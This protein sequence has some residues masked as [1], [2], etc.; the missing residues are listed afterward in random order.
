[1]SKWL[2]FMSD[3]A[4]EID[5][6]SVLEVFMHRKEGITFV[7]ELLSTFYLSV[8][9]A[10]CADD[11]VL[12]RSN[13]LPSCFPVCRI[14]VIARSVNVYD[15]PSIPSKKLCKLT[16]MNSYDAFDRFIA[17]DGNIFYRV[18]AGWCA[19]LDKDAFPN[20]EVIN[21]RPQTHAEKE[22]WSHR[23]SDLTYKQK[24]KQLGFCSHYSLRRFGSSLLQMLLASISSFNMKLIQV[25]R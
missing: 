16:P 10:Y 1:M 13:D 18:E 25:I 17:E 3:T 20:L 14:L 2:L 15:R 6:N 7:N 5:S 19:F 9:K 12:F 4:W 24:S 23:L 21:M 11:F 22:R 8:T